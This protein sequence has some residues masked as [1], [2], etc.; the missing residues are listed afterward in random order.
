MLKIRRL[1]AR[2]K[3][4]F[5]QRG[6]MVSKTTKNPTFAKLML[7]NSDTGLYLWYQNF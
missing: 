5:S 1:F 4:Y 6:E 3:T 2:P 7:I